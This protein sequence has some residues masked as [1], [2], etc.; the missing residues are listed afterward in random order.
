MTEYPRLWLTRPHD[1]SVA[2]AQELAPYGI[3]GIVAPVLRILP[4]PIHALP[5][6]TPDA[7]LLTSR[8]ATHAL[9]DLPAAWRTL[10]AYCVGHATAAA[11]TEHG[12]Q[13][14]LPGTSDVQTILPRI[15]NALS[16]GSRLLYLA[17]DETR[18]D[19]KHALAAYGVDVTVMVVYSAIAN[20]ALDEPLRMGLANGSIGGAVFFSP[21]SAR[22]ACLLIEKA[23]LSA[24]THRMAAYCLSANVASEASRLR[25]LSLHSCPRPT[26]HSLRELIV[27]HRKKTG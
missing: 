15:G 25:W 16:T 20:A 19:V 2:F 8:H 10:P 11:A 4:H 26:R 17:G 23:G 27:S 13:N 22:I 9:A 6:A 21:R 14:I 12:L 5:R 24:C 3:A 7:L 18:T 1:D